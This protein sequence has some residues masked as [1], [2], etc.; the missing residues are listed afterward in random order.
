MLEKI[1][2][3]FTIFPISIPI[4]QI[5]KKPNNLTI[6]KK[7]S[8]TKK[9]KMRTATLLSA[10]SA[11][12][13]TTARLVGI[14][15]PST[16]APS[17]NYTLTLITENYIQAVADVAIAWGYSTPPGFPGS[18]GFFTGSAYLGPSKSNQLKN[19]PIE[20]AAP[21]SLNVGSQYVLG[22]SLLSLYGASGGPVVTLFNVTVNVGEEVSQDV[23]RSN[24]FTSFSG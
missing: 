10:L 1:R 20:V 5:T 2:Y 7:P 12:S 19:V 13:L 4:S 9:K 18:L 3:Q 17:Q 24:G 11:L 14:S 21:Q 15:A 6:K 16:I 22:V 8:T 23:V